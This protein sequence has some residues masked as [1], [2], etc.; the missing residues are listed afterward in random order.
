MIGHDADAADRARCQHR[1]DPRQHELRRDAERFRDG[2]IRPRHARQSG[3]QR[4]HEG[5]IELRR[6][7]SQGGVH[8]TV[9][10]FNST[11]YSRSFGN[12]YT[13]NPVSASIFAI[14]AAMP[15]GV[16]VPSTNHMLSAWSRA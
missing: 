7:I 3:L 6:G 9:R 11:K 8:L 13:G 10:S 2:V 4:A 14:A 15:S 1:L 12:A 16:S 5:A